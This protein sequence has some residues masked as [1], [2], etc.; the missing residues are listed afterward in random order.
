MFKKKRGNLKNDLFKKKKKNGYLPLPKKSFLIK[1][2]SKKKKKKK[3][4]LQ[5]EINYSGFFFVFS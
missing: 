2:T 4:K 3:T 5:M 1:I